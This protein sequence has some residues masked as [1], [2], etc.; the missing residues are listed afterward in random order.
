MQY[1]KIEWTDHFSESSWKTKEEMKEWASKTKQ[2][3]AVTVGAVSY[4]DDD[5]VVLSASFDGESVFG[6]NM[7]IFK[8]NIIN[9]KK[10]KI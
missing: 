5:I 1:Y 10:I 3:V 9:R 4:E 8:T 2:N 6:D 7:A